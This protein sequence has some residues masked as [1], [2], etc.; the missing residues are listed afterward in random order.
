MEGAA[1]HLVCLENKIPFLQIRGISNWV[2]ERDKSQWKI[3]E[4]AEAVAHSI[5]NFIKKL[6]PTP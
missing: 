4:A 3:P 6:N 1:L 5:K 2:G